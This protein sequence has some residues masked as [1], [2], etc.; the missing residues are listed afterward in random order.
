MDARRHM[1]GHESTM[2]FASLISIILVSHG[3]YA[4]VQEVPENA[5]DVAH[6]N[7]LHAPGLLSGTDLRETHDKKYEF[8]QH[9][10]LASWAAETDDGRRHLSVLTLTHRLKMF[11]W[12]LPML[13]LRVTATQVGPGLVYLHFDCFFGKGIFV[14]SLTPQEPLYQE[15]TH[16]IYTSWT[17]PQFMAKFYLFGEAKQVERD[18]MIWNNKM[19]RKNPVLIKEDTLI[20]KHRRW[21]SQFYSENSPTYESVMNGGLDW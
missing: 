20:A 10:W 17:I 5:A 15:L 8:L 16:T 19:Y 4:C 21:Y 18:V 1:I 3:L 11:G 2:L 7:Y 13:D 9:E 12:A 14:Q 6:L